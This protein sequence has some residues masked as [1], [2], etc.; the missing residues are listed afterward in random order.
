MPTRTLRALL[1]DWDGTLWDSSEASFRS[2]VRLFE[3]Y[4][5]AFD[6]ERFEATYA[7]DWYATYRAVGLRED[8]WPEADARWM[9]EYARED[10]RLLPG[11][12]DALGQ[13]H[14]LGLALGLVTSGSRER[15]LREL[16]ALSIRHL[17]RS[18]VCAEDVERRKPHPEGLLK[19]LR[20][21][22]ISP[23]ESAYVGDSPEDVE[24][25]RAAGA[26][27]V[28]I[29]GGFPNR[30]ALAAS[31]PAVLA[32]SLAEAVQALVC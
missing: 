16:E 12:R 19:A 8:L 22:G 6:R 7:P 3:S 18:V 17:F 4:G 5:I 9:R 29:P 15:V 30:A 28:G 32:P 10:G 24:M 21:M 27:P 14:A 11:A 31:E 23:E 1:F 13:A 26:L 2:Y 20:D 25:A